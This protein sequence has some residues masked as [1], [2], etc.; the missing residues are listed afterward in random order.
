MDSGMF[1]IDRHRSNTKKIGI[2]R[3]TPLFHSH[4]ISYPY[5][6]VC[7]SL[8]PS[9]LYRTFKLTATRKVSFY[10]LYPLNEA[11]LKNIKYIEN[12]LQ[13]SVFPPFPAR[14]TSFVPLS[15]YQKITIL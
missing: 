9:Q 8:L 1:K 15:N 6:I 3:R 4:F 7:V 10:F 11:E 12:N 13:V 14:P 2:L 5:E